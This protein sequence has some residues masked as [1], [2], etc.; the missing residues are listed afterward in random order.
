MIALGKNGALPGPGPL[1]IIL[2]NI[3]E[4]GPVASRQDRSYLHHVIIDP[5]NTYIVIPDL[6]GDRCRVF[7]YDKHNV[8]PIVEVGEL[9]AE[10]GSGPRHGFFRVMANGDTFFFHNGELSQ[11]VYSYRVKYQRKGLSFTRI[12]DIPALDAGLPA[13]TAPASEIAMSV[14]SHNLANPQSNILF[15]V[16]NISLS[17]IIVSLSC[18]IAKSPSAHRP[19]SGPGLQTRYLHLPSRKMAH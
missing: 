9:T 13:T 10:P 17:P 15:L 7:T 3:T 4:T 14:S 12:F 11:K 1:Q 16:A 2:P 8:A 18:Q 5:T 19:Y 6:G